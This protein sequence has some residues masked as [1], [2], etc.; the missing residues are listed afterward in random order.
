M[1]ADNDQTDALTEL[2]QG[3]GVKKSTCKGGIKNNETW[4]E[5]Y[6]KLWY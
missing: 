1:D 4:R 3:L 2:Y 5:G 6:R